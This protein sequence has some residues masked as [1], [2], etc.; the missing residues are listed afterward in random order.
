MVGA[1][2]VVT[3]D[4]LAR[5][6]VAGNPARIVGYVEATRRRDRRAAPA[7]PGSDG[8]SVETSVGGVF[9]HHLRQAEDLRGR[10]TAAEFST[11]IPFVPQRYF[12]VFDVPGKEVRGEHAHRR[13]HQFV[14]CARGSMT[15][16]VDDGTTSEEIVLDQPCLG[17]HVP[18]RI[19][20]A[21]YNY[22]ADAL[23]VVFASDHYDPDDYIRDYD[24]FLTLIGR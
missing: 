18:P 8:A 10:L 19:W 24:E 22:S 12:M 16:V 23:L 5:T 3:H 4:V 13:C 6:A 20:A 2:A 1:G 17:V 21:Q 9:L 14:V 11:E 15:L 7:R